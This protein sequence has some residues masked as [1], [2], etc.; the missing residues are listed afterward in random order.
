MDKTDKTDC[1]S[2]IFTEIILLMKEVMKEAYKMLEKVPMIETEISI[3]HSEADLEVTITQEGHA[4]EKD[5][6]EDRWQ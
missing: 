4:E 1:K 5:N 2:F 6:Y 3:F